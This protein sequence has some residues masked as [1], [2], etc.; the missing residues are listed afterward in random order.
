MGRP[1]TGKGTARNER[2][3]PLVNQVRGDAYFDGVPA[4]GRGHTIEPLRISP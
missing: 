2:D 1:T 3:R 4:C